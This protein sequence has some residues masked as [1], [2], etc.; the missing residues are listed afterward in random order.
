[1][2][3]LEWDDKKLDDLRE[4]LKSLEKPR[5]SAEDFDALFNSASLAPLRSYIDDTE[6]YIDEDYELDQEHYYCIYCFAREDI[7]WV[8]LHVHDPNPNLDGRH[9]QDC[10]IQRALDLLK[11]QDVNKGK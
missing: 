11:T 4:V 8:T 5:L 6:H 10:P 1:M 9:E 3:N 2:A 7:D